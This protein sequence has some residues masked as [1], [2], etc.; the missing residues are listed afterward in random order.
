MSW[1]S[2]KLFVR[3]SR[4]IFKGIKLDNIIVDIFIIPCGILQKRN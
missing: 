2:I 3:Y 1:L 4:G